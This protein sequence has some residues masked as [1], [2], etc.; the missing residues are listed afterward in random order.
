MRS[1]LRSDSRALKSLDDYAIIRR[2]RH[3]YLCTNGLLLDR[4]YGKG[5]PHPR[6]SINVHLDG[7]RETHDLVTDRRGVFDKAIEMIREGKRLGYTVC[8]NTTVYRE[9]SIDEI[10]QNTSFEWAT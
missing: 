6:L 9:T 3:I 4:F 5:R 8:T 1:D 10:E 7:M 2:K